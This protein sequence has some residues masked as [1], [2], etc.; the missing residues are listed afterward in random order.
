MKAHT[1]NSEKEFSPQDFIQKNTQMN[2][3]LKKTASNNLRV[4]TRTI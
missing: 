4:A 1:R 3:Q 2:S